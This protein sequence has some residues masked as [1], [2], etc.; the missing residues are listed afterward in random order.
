MPW[1]QEVWFMTE[2]LNTMRRKAR[3]VSGWCQEQFVVTCAVRQAGIRK[4][5]WRCY[6]W[7]PSW[8]PDAIVWPGLLMNTYYCTR[9]S[10]PAGL[11]SL[12]LLDVLHEY[13]CVVLACEKPRRAS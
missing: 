7:L 8:A 5:V 13:A 2:P 1:R 11:F 3:E 4:Q 10:R 9:F 12:C 6:C